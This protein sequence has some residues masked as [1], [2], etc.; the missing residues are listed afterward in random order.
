MTHR[1]AFLVWTAAVA[2]YVMAIAG[3]SSFGVAGLEAI[4]RFAI[5][6]TTLSLFTVIQLG[7]YAGAQLPV[8]LLLDRIG[9][10]PV[11]IGG[12]LIM[13][14]GQVLLGV[15]DT[16]GM[17]LAVRILIGLG[18][19]SAYTAVLRLLPGWFAPRQIPLMTQLTGMVGQLGQVISSIPFALVLDYFGWQP[20]FVASGGAAALVALAAATWV[21]D[22]P[23]NCVPTEGPDPQTRSRNRGGSL[24]TVLAEPAVWLGFFTHFSCGFMPMVFQLLWGSPFLQVVNGMSKAGAAAML[25]I[26]PAAGLVFG[27]I[28]G[29]LTSVHPLRRTW[30]V[31]GSVILGVVAWIPFLIGKP[32]PV[33]MVV[34]LLLALSVPSVCAAIGFD[35]VR[36]FVDVHRTGTGN[37]I[38]NMGGFVAT[39]LGAW[40]I[41]S[42]LD[43]SSSHGVFTAA[44]FRVAMAS[45]CVVIGIG[46][47]GVTVSRSYVRRNMARDGVVVPPIR[48]VWHRYRTIAK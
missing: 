38:V 27:P 12:A 7:V 47:I 5:S 40:L 45:Q 44:D 15:A 10:R 6:A 2:V 35:F 20:A 32:K 43:A 39:L 31:Y 1:G 33:W 26:Q 4:D 36:T 3:R 25:L 29:R 41:G 30:M 9:I 17:A 37:G 23:G 46:L 11:L 42:V 13:A 14:A 18:D 19:A 21:K 48:D 16:L 34:L 8:G 22:A 24:R 28:I